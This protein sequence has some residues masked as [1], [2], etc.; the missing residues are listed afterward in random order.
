MASVA[1]EAAEE[2][3]SDPEFRWT[4][5]EDGVLFSV[6]SASPKSNDRVAP[7]PSCSHAAV[8]SAFP[9]S[10]PTMGSSSLA[11]SS[12]CCV[13]SIDHSH[14]PPSISSALHSLLARLSQTPIAPGLGSCLAI[15]DSGATDHMLPDKSAFI[16]Y[17]KTKALTLTKKLL[18]VNIVLFAKK[19]RLKL[20]LPCAC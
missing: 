20:F 18:S 6:D 15:A 4:G 8:V 7:Y 13:S 19:V 12:S 11:A 9:P 1:D 10:S 17:K 14:S 5:D 16:S 2:Y 3:D